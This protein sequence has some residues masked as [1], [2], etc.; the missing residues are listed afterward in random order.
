M[1]F[2]AF[3]IIWGVIL[4]T[5]GCAKERVPGP[6]TTIIEQCSVA[7]SELGTLVTCPDGS[8]IFIEA[9]GSK[10]CHVKRRPRHE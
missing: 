1:E 10:T 9:E 3:L 4:A 8:T 7:E 2:S 5:I 6:T